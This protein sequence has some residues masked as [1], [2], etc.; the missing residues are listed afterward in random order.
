MIIK[1]FFS[2][3]HLFCSNTAAKAYYRNYSA[4]LKR[5]Y[6]NVYVSETD[7]KFEISLD[8]RRLKTPLGNKFLLPNEGLAV[9]VAT[10]WDTQRDVIERHNMHIT[11][12]CNTAIDN[13]CKLS[14]ENIAEDIIQ[15]LSSDTTCFRSSEPLDFAVLQKN[16]WDPVLAWFTNR[17]NVKVDICNDVS[18]VPVSDQA[19]AVMKKH[20]LS[21]NPWCLVGITFTVENLKSLILT[22][23]VINYNIDVEKAVALSRLETLFQT[24][25]WGTVEWAHSVDEA[26]IKARV[27][28]GV[29]FTYLNEGSTDTV[30][31]SDFGKVPLFGRAR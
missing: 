14:S 1:S 7:G 20:M 15:F 26:Q 29:L 8:K 16:E 25:Q 24:K 17:Y 9:A 3:L 31:K 21:Y 12:L 4:P 11:A 28:A 6:K 10:E 2:N 27:A 19:L 18:G 30:I 5:F 13:P 23:A 22:M